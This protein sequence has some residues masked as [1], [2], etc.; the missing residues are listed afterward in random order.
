MSTTVV[1]RKENL[2]VKLEDDQS[3][4]EIADALGYPSSWILY[5][6]QK[7]SREGKNWKWNPVDAQT[8][9]EETSV[10]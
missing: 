6:K 9:K 7:L 1:L 10:E 8:P 5:M 2:A 3:W 4:L